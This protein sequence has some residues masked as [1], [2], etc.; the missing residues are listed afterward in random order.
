MIHV[1]EGVRS[2]DM[3]RAVYRER[4]RVNINKGDGV[5]R[6]DCVYMLSYTLS[7]ARV[8]GLWAFGRESSK[9]TCPALSIF[10]IRHHFLLPIHMRFHGDDRENYTS[11]AEDSSPRTVP[12][13]PKSRHRRTDTVP[14]G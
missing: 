4:E 9:E 3:A 8:E 2:I 1:T 7:S 14:L 5:P 12:S 10:A 6:Q 11:G 13:T